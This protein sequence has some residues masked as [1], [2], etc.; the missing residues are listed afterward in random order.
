M[1]PSQATPKAS[2]ACVFV[3]IAGFLLVP[4]LFLLNFEC[5]LK[6]GPQWL[7]LTIV[8]SAIVC[9]SAIALARIPL[10]ARIGLVLATVVLWLLVLVAL[11][12][13]YAE[14]IF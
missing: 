9:A 3:W 2:C 8:V 6:L 14:F 10:L 13:I 4:L 12:R 1:S 7:D 5:D 11:V